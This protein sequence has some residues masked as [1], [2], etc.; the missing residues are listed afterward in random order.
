M[1]RIKAVIFDVGGVLQLGGKTRYT[2]KDIH[3]SGVHET[4]AKKLK[5]SIDQYFDSIDSAYT[6][7]M[8]GQISKAEL[9]NTISKNL[10]I[11]KKKLEKIYY[12][13]YKKKYKKNKGL[14]K[15]AKKLKKNKYKIAILSDQWHLSKPAHIPNEDYKLFDKL[16]VSCDVGLRKPNREIYELTLKKLNLTPKEV[17]FVDNQSWNIIPA[18]KLGMKTILFTD[19]K[20]TKIQLKKLGV[21]LWI[22]KVS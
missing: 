3:V 17:I 13:L 6:K 10:G 4:I 11:S 20:N 16:I 19:N 2:R 9:L 15:I 22:G 5:I 7:S 8:E 12:S 18:N 21:K 14:Y 1:E